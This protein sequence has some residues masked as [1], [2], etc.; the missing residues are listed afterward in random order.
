MAADDA[1]FMALAL[2]LAKRA[3]P[4]PNPRVGAVLA[5]NGRV[6]GAGFHRGSGLP[7]AEIEA[8]RDAKR[9]TRNQP[10]CRGATLYVTLEP[11]SHTA[12]R[13]PPCTGA[14]AKEGISRV[15]YAMKDPNPLVGGAAELRR[16]GIPASRVRHPAARRRAERMNCRYIAA[17]R[18][19]PFVMI[20][21]AVSADGKTATRTGDSKWISSA[22]SRER[23]HRLRAEFDA[24]MVGS[25]TVRAD[26]PQLTT[27]LV[28]GRS[29]WRVIVDH[30]LRIPLSSRVLR[31]RD[32]KTIIAAA[33]GARPRAGRMGA[34][35]LFCGRGR[36]DLRL[37]VRALGAMGIRRMLI[38][39]GNELNAQAL[40]A[41]I[42]D[43]IMLFV[44][45][46]LIGG[47]GALPVVGGNGAAT[48]AGAIPL[49]LAKTARSGPDL[50]LVYDVLRRGKAGL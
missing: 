4:F 31:N 48:V 29:P 11:C 14:I 39:G 7:H 35:V 36:V 50:V 19:K 10:A 24:V 2:A 44:A 25:G 38:E 18:K 15:V 49:R 32:G 1:K 46:K 6:V 45:P 28:R 22:E 37:L 12:K 26:D 33:E 30:D 9:K 20:K 34:R 8:I 41:G 40:E 5:K 13:T 42:V 23:V 27:R 17:I 47:R 16:R 21:M 43:R 3:D